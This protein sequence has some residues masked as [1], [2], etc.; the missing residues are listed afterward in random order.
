M[1]TKG[2]ARMDTDERCH[3]IPEPIMSLAQGAEQIIVMI[4]EIGQR[5]H[6]EEGYRNARS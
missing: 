2:R 5:E 6:A 1:M 3:G 4:N